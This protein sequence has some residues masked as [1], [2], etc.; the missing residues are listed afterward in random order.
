GITHHGEINGRRLV[1]A[2]ELGAERALR[3]GAP[4][5]PVA[6]E[7]ERGA[8]ERRRGKRPAARTERVSSEHALPGD[9]RLRADRREPLLGA[10]LRLPRPQ[11]LD[12]RAEGAHDP[13]RAVGGTLRLP[14]ARLL[15]RLVPRALITSKR[16]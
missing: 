3:L 5:L 15:P 6:G 14:D 9:R 10:L 1:P 13:R 2:L 16:R 12:A 8:R 7:H 11:R 4:C